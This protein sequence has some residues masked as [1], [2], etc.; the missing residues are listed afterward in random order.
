M[1]DKFATFGFKG[2]VVT[3]QDFFQLTKIH[4]MS[5]YLCTY[6]F[7]RLIYWIYWINITKTNISNVYEPLL[8]WS[9]ICIYFKYTANTLPKYIWNILQVYLKHASNI[10][11]AANKYYSSAGHH[12]II[13]KKS[14]IQIKFSMVTMRQWIK[15]VLQHSLCK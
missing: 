12:K 3:V 14:T 7:R 6:N 9:M 4:K 10:L 15:L 1:G 11:S 2:I 8:K 5:N 13:N